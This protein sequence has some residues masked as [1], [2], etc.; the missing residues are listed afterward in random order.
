MKPM[1]HEIK[2]EIINIEV[3]YCDKL[4]SKMN[5]VGTDFSAELEVTRY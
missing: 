5:K 1:K 2:E 3:F 4:K